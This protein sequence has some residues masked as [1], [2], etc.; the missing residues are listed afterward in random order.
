M[1]IS[2]SF[3]NISTN[4]KYDVNPGPQLQYKN[5][6]DGLQFCNQFSLELIQVM[7]ELFRFKL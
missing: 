2:I 6:H 7:I 3:L 1:N 4:F 5:Q